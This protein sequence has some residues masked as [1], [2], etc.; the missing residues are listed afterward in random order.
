MTFRG[1]SRHRGA[2]SGALRFLFLVAA[3]CAA[4]LSPLLSPL[5]AFAQEGAAQ[6]PEPPPPAPAPPAPGAPDAS[7]TP[8]AP[9][10]EPSAPAAPTDSTAPSDSPAPTDSTAP[11]DP[12][13]RSD[14]RPA[15]TD[16]PAPSDS[17][18]APA[19]APTTPTGSRSAPAAAPP[20]ARTPDS[21][22][23]P[24]APPNGPAQGAGRGSGAEHPGTIEAPPPEKPTEH[25]FDR[26]DVRGYTQ[27][28]Y[29]HLGQTN[30]RLVNVQGDKSWGGEGGGFFLRRAR[31][32]LY[33]KLHPQVQLYLQ[34]DFVSAPSGDSLNFVQ[35]RD[36]YADIS[37]PSTE[38]RVRVGQ[39]KVPFGFENMQSS[40]NRLPLDR[41]DALNSA[42]ANER[43]IGL[44]F[45]YA[46]VE[47]RRRFKLLG[48]SKLK[49]TGDYGMV[50]LGIYNGQTANRP[51]K[52]E[53][54]H[55]VARVTYPF[56]LGEQYVEV[57]ASGYVG[58]YVI[59]K[60]PEIGGG[61]EFRDARAQAT[62]VLYPQPFG[63]QVEYNIGVGPELDAREVLQ[64]DGSRVFTGEVRE[65]FLHGGYALASLVLGDFIPYVR[66]FYYEGGK[67][68]ETNAPSY[69]VRE[70]ELGVEWQAIQALEL[71][72]AYTIAERT[73]AEPPYELES[74]RLF[75]F[76]LQ[77]NY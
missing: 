5:P 48:S 50:G 66:G 1:T 26:I 29:N 38:F 52:N 68:H 67:K 17:P 61:E 42:V 54:K 4:P 56:Q 77:V 27:L 58:K 23:A 44:F 63:L 3:G 62:F 41:S 64:P 15:P 74:G 32:I 25:F 70:V 75:R 30:P 46:P 31:I 34:P 59:K 55:V 21:A 65:Q 76:Q 2:P 60:D 37:D 14:S 9:T 69:T 40:S 8:R 57:G 18:S 43:D 28:R 73:F 10:S 11:S 72:G 19:A 7:T 24:S 47:V 39:S 71:V 6:A 22:P 35:V 53:N 20:S 16:S 13:A 49:G 33:G 36:W 51:E 12:P 45:Y